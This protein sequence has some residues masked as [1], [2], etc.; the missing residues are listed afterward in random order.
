MGSRYSNIEEVDDRIEKNYKFICELK[1]LINEENDNEKKCIL[2]TLIGQYYMSCETGIYIDVD[3]EEQICKLASL[4]PNK[5]IKK[6]DEADILIV[7]S[8]AAT[9]GGHSVI[10]SN[11]P[12]W[13]EDNTY[14]L[15]T[16]RQNIEDI[17]LFLKDSINETGGQIY[18][19]HGNYFE[20]AKKL[21]A[22]S[23]NYNAILMFTHMD[24]IVPLL[25]YGTDS[26]NVPVYFYNH[27]DFRF[28][29]GMSIA[30]AVLNLCEFDLNKTER[31]RGYLGKNYV[32][33]FPNNGELIIDKEEKLCDRQVLIAKQEEIAKKYNIN[34]KK[35]LIVSAGESMK[36][37]D[38]IG[39]SFCDFIKKL[40]T[41]KS[42][43]VECVVIGPSPSGD[44]WRD[45]S[46]E[47]KG[48]A[49]AIGFI[50]RAEMEI[51]ISLSD[52]YIVSY[53]MG[54][55]GAKYAIKYKIPHLAMSMTDRIRESFD[56]KN[57]AIDEEELSRKTE[58]ALFLNRDRYVSDGYNYINKDEWQNIW[59]KVLSESK[60]H[61]KP[62]VIQKRVVCEMERLFCQ[63]LATEAEET[64]GIRNIVCNN[65]LEE[66][67]LRCIVKYDKEN[68][69]GLIPIE[70]YQTREQN[71]RDLNFYE[72]MYRKCDMLYQVT[73]KWLEL[74]SNGWSIAKYLDN[75]S[76]KKIAIYGYGNLGRN[77]LVQLLH[78][79]IEIVEIIDKKKE[80]CLNNNGV[81]IPIIKPDNYKNNIDAI[82]NTTVFDNEII[83][84]ELLSNVRML[85]LIDIINYTYKN[86]YQG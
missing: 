66:N 79:D 83:R 6:N 74:N 45:L 18:C 3:L 80:E 60:K 56:A 28:S 42:D 48:A 31:D 36:Y 12:K 68:H 67:I 17:P 15:V 55:H 37:S 13:D 5:N 85:S 78:T 63:V 1:K 75:S 2:Y 40:L 29:Y 71:S 73:S 53:P 14:S 76:Y 59:K 4:V 27:A 58:D 22:L 10:A 44:K 47:T 82:I 24:D 8:E 65:L 16:T 81:I 30:D 34:R 57:L 64:D 62:R 43:E 52:L 72:P 84:E 69:L 25:A 33:R 21:R 51:L 38:I 61:E 86:I 70:Y 19:L 77:L 26:W 41:N 50:D 35:K 23:N 11:W 49:R 46:V 9:V 54:A 32:L 7:M 39:Y 20:K